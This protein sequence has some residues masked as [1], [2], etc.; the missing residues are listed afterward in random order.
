MSAWYLLHWLWNGCCRLWLNRVFTTPCASPQ[1]PNL[2]QSLAFS[3]HQ[4]GNSFL[5]LYRILRGLSQNGQLDTTISSGVVLFSSSNY[6]WGTSL[7]STVA[8]ARENGMFR[9]SSCHCPAASFPAL[10]PCSLHWLIPVAPH[11]SV[12]VV[13]QQSWDSA[14]EFFFVSLFLN[15]L[16]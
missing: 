12:S 6:R 14:A 5:A 9:Y 1:L 10:R 2:W 15:L 3:L 11:K 8:A 16:H 13:I 7:P 4:W